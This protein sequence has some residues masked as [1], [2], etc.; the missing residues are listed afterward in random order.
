MIALSGV[1]ISVLASSI[2]SVWQSRVQVRRYRD[3]IVQEFGIRVFE[4]R[5]EAYPPLYASLSR[6]MK[7][8][9]FGKISPESIA[10][11]L[12]EL[13]TWDSDHSILFSRKAGRLCYTLR[14]KLHGLSELSETEI[15]RR[16]PAGSQEE[17]FSEA[18]KLTRHVGA[19]ELALK[20]ELGAYAFEGPA[21]VKD[22]E[23][24]ST[25]RAAEG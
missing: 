2:V 12:E 10:R 21:R 24:P 18:E 22:D 14:H 17:R 6:F 5:M 8:V 9:E 11:L 25:M 4:K 23:P 16:F 3:E 19:L 1:V 15:E 13:Q 7:T 20:N